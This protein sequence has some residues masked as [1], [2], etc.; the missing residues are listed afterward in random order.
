[1]AISFHLI[2]V[3]PS[4]EAARIPVSF[5]S[6]FEETDR[7]VS[8]NKSASMKEGKLLPRFWLATR[9]PAQQK[10]VVNRYNRTSQVVEYRKTMG[11]SVEGF[12]DF[13]WGGVV[14]GLDGEVATG[15][16]IG[17]ER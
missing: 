13:G 1:L 2:S 15:E 5:T 14:F 12:D 4:R 11:F 6:T 9:K 7:A 8:P 17:W 3:P 10:M 16:E